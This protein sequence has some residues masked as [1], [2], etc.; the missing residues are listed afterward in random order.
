MNYGTLSKKESY[1]FNRKVYL[2][3]EDAEG[4]K[5]WLEKPYWDCG[6][7]WGFGYIVTYKGNKKPSKAQEIRK[8]QHATNFHPK[9]VLNY[10][11]ILVK[12][13]F[14]ENEAWKLAELFERF[15]TFKNLAKLYSRGWG[16]ITFIDDFNMQDNKE[17]EKINKKILPKIM[18][19]IIKI[20]KP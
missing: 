2:L 14:T 9:W 10:D 16:N 19:E 13:T 7:Y 17:A 20:L 18:D 5:Y 1:A 11:S 8:I 12:T 4:T 3:G 15:Y 6:W